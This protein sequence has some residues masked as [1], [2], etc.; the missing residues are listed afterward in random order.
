M[1]CYN[2]VICNFNSVN[3][4]DEFYIF[5][6]SISYGLIIGLIYDFYRTFRYYSKPKKLVSFIE[7]LI[8]WLVITFV[9][10]MFLV[11][12]TDGIIRGFIV[13]GFVIGYVFYLKLILYLY[14]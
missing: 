2:S 13:V 1:L 7:D 4:I 14:Q 11:K 9:F 8:F 3:L 6:L 5:L 10:F 12:R